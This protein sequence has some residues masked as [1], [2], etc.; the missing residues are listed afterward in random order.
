MSAGA[1]TVYNTER[2]IAGNIHTRQVRLAEGDY[3]RGMPLTYDPANDRY[4]YS[5]NPLIIVAFFL[6]ANE[7]EVEE[8]AWR[9]VIVGGDIYQRGIV[10]EFGN[11]LTIDEDF[12]ALMGTR[13]FYIQRT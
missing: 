3:S 10:D 7:I 5:A 2:L 8:N 6:G 9:A 1:F 4:T 13:G 12:I 11:P